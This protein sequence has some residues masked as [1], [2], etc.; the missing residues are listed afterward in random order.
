[1]RHFFSIKVVHGQDDMCKGFVCPRG[2]MCVPHTDESGDNYTTCECPTSCPE[3]V[4]EPVCSYYNTQF[5]SR[6]E[7]HRFGCA[8]DLTMK[9]KNQGSCSSDGEWFKPQ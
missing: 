8:H 4:T 6:C 1:M 5:N 9:V 7:M 3:E 2:R